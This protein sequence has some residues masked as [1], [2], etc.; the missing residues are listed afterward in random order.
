[1]H[2]P[3]AWG[4]LSVFI[5]VA[6]DCAVAGANGDFAAFEG[7]LAGHQGL[8]NHTLAGT[9]VPNSEKVQGRNLTLL[10]ACGQSL[11]LLGL[12]ALL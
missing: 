6:T 9:C 2:L 7:I 3:N 12:A 1:M 8:I 10:F 5:G 4:N 11:F